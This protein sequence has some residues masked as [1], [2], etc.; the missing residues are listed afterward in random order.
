MNVS[1]LRA[2]IVK[3]SIDS[4]DYAV[5]NI[6]CNVYAN[7]SVKSKILTSLLVSNKIQL[8]EPVNSTWIKVNTDSIVGYIMVGYL[9]KSTIPSKFIYNDKL[10]KDDMVL[11]DSIR[12]ATEKA[13][14]QKRKNYLYKKYGKTN[15]DKILSGTIWLGMSNTMAEESIGRPKSNNRTVGSWG[16]HEQW[17]YNDIYLYFENGKLT[18][19]QD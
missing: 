2:Q 3:K 7:P 14:L 17:V 11:N 1:T 6:A 19:W 4:N 12:L 18:S 8:E 15:G 16:V 13:E 5:V 10:T 9:E